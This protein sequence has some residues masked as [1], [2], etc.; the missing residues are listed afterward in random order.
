MESTYKFLK[1]LAKNNN[2][3]WF[4]INRKTYESCKADF[5][6]LLKQI[7]EKSGL[8]DKDIANLEAKKCLFRI[9][10][11]I[12]F[13]KDKSPYKLNFGA[14]LEPGGKKTFI[15]GY[16]L[17][18]EPGNCFLAGGCYQPMPEAL[19]SIRQE[20]DYNTSEF[21]KI[22]SNK[23]FRLYFKELSQD[24][25]LKTAPKGYDKTHPDIS[26]FQLKSFV[27]VHHFDDELL[28][29]KNFPV[30]AS[31]VFKAMYPLNIFLRRC[32]N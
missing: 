23:D 30:Y 22:I 25:K 5:V 19:A 12:R 8:F 28:F 27:V 7:I 24:D 15:P 21:K 11:D 29:N 16:Y 1:Q 20:I 32:L 4:D 18:I 31:K 3:E 2:K 9:N 10:K 14:A 26:L 6:E 13:S 17:H